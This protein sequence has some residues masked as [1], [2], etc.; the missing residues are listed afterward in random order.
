MNEIDIDEEEFN[1]LFKA[2]LKDMILVAKGKIGYGGYL[3]DIAA[4]SIPR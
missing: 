1:E 2:D 3:E 4:G